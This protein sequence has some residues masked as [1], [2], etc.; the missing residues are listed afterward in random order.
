MNL[1][2]LTTQLKREA[3]FACNCLCSCTFLHDNLVV[4]IFFHFYL[5]SFP[6]SPLLPISLEPLARANGDGELVFCMN[7]WALSVLA[8]SHP[9]VGEP[10][11]SMEPLTQDM[12]KMSASVYS[13]TGVEPRDRA[14][15]LFSSSVLSSSLS[16]FSQSIITARFLFFV[17]LMLATCL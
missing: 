11:E 10:F 2:T 3:T 8:P 16:L 4:I 17:L 7:E 1:R 6:L 14:S 15:F 9:S 5:L 13:L 12:A